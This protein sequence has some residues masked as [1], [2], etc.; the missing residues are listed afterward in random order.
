[1]FVQINNNRLNVEVMGPDD[2][3]VMI[4][5]HGAPGLGTL[6]EPKASFGPLSD[7]YNCLLYTS[8]SPR[9]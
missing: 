8:P 4:V 9:D 2:A 5:H 3:P 7:V 6:A 1:M